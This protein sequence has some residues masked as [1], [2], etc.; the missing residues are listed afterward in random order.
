MVRNYKKKGII[1]NFKPKVIDAAVTAVRNKLISVR[2]A[3]KEFGI[4]PTTLHN[5]VQA[6]VK[7]QKQKCQY[8]ILRFKMV[9]YSCSF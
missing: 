8:Q 6:R 5:W 3:S 7:H 4:P 9:R 1:G 2:T